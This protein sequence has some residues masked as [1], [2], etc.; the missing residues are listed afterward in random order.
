MQLSHTGEVPDGSCPLFL[1]LQ[2]TQHF[3]NYHVLVQLTCT[4]GN[5]HKWV[6][7]SK[8]WTSM[9]TLNNRL[10]NRRK[11]W[12]WKPAGTI[13]WLLS[14]EQG[15]PKLASKE[16]P[17]YCYY[18]TMQE[19]FPTVTLRQDKPF[20][21]FFCHLVQYSKGHFSNKSRNRKMPL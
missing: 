6:K 16:L 20:L 15:M 13:L 21:W 9:Q 5:H 4:M 10:A 12:N 19:S 3:I 8:Q 7:I 2:F 17:M 14:I 18:Y 11:E 1:L